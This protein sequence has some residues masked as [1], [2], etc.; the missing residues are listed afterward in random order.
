M[1][2]ENRAMRISQSNAKHIAAAQAHE[3]AAEAHRQA[4]RLLAAGNLIAAFDLTQEADLSSS[5]ASEASA[6]AVFHLTS[7][8]SGNVRNSRPVA[9]LLV[10]E[11]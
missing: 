6:M 1:S 8:A 10:E 5:M 4:A 11:S 7:D 9:E 3:V 2:S